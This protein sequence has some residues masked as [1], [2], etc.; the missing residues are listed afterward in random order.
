M[1]EPNGPG[2]PKR[3][4]FSNDQVLTPADFE[5]EQQYVREKLKRHNR[6]LHG[7]GIVSGLKVKIVSGRIIVEPGLALDCEGNELLIETPQT[8]AAPSLVS[9]SDELSSDVSSSGASSK[10]LPSSVSS[11][12]V[13]SEALSSIASLAEA[14]PK[15]FSS[16]ASSPVDWHT[17]YLNVRFVEEPAAPLAASATGAAANTS[18][19]LTDS[20]ALEVAPENYNRGHR[21]LR[22]RWLACGQPHALTLAKLRRR[23]HGWTVDRSYRPPTVK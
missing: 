1:V 17:A 3:S 5:R 8:V 16:S 4:R 10:A 14:S 21:H 7:F 22:A 9:S 13:F 15:A 18:V 12:A 19:Y 11:S 6:T 23:S 2:A 20:F